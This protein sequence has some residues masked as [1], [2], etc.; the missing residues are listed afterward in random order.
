MQ[1]R[2]LVRFTFNP[3]LQEAALI[4]IYTSV[5]VLLNRLILTTS[6]LQALQT[7]KGEA[8]GGGLCPEQCVFNI[9]IIV[10]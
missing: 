8:E 5:P 10:K 3:V 9:L 7:N 6:L 1:S 2:K 4:I